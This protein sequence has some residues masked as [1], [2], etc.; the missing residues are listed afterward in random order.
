MTQNTGSI[1]RTLRIVVGAILMILA[2]SG[3]IGAWGFIGIVPLVTGLIGFCPLYR[4]V[5]IST[6]AHRAG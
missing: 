4:M 6:C 3:T 5:G 1:D 2:A